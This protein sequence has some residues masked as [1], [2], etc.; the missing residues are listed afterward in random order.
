MSINNKNPHFTYSLLLVS[1][2]DC[3]TM[4]NFI[5]HYFIYEYWIFS[6]STPLSLIRQLKLFSIHIQ[7]QSSLVN[8]VAPFFLLILLGTANHSFFFYQFRVQL[9]ISISSRVY[10][11]PSVTTNLPLAQTTSI[12]LIVQRVSIS[13]NVASFTC[14]QAISYL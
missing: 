12:L 1:M 7:W 6:L 2:K 10:V 3:R 13:L 14:V 4:Y 8:T 5:F 11:C 9:S